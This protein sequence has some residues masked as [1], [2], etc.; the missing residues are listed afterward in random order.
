MRL[1]VWESDLNLLCSD[2]GGSNNNG[3]YDNNKIEKI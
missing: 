3:E 2:N 1:K